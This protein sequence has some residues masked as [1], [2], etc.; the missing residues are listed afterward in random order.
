M[1]TA[2]PIL[3]SIGLNNTGTAIARLYVTKSN[4]L[5]AIPLDVVS[6]AKLASAGVEIVNGND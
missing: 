2:Q 5:V 3:V 1:T 6:F 4:S